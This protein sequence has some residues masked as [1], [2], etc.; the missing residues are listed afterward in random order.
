MYPDPSGPLRI[1]V[2]VP[3]RVNEN[4]NIKEDKNAVRRYS[5]RRYL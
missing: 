3:K 1:N 2:A 5:K 4:K